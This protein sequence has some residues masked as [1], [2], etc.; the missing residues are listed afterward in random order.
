MAFL[1]TY[2]IYVNRVQYQAVIHYSTCD[3]LAQHGGV[4]SEPGR[5]YYITGLVD[6]DEARELANIEGYEVRECEQR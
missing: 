3:H 4:P 6:L 5:Q 1:G 2:S